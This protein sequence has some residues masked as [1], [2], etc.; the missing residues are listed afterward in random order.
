MASILNDISN[1]S[2]QEFENEIL[3]LFYEKYKRDATSEDF[4]DII[5]LS[6]ANS[7]GKDILSNQVL[8]TILVDIFKGVYG[9]AETNLQ[10]PILRKTEKSIQPKKEYKLNMDTDGNVFIFYNGN[11]YVLPEE[12]SKTLL[13]LGFLHDELTFARKINNVIVPLL[14]NINI[15]DEKDN[16]SHKDKVQELYNKIGEIAKIQYRDEKG[17]YQVEDIDGKIN[18]YLSDEFSKAIDSITSTLF[19]DLLD[20]KNFEG[21][22]FSIDPRPYEALKDMLELGFRIKKD[23][24]IEQKLLVNPYG[25]NFPIYNDAQFAFIDKTFFK[26]TP[27]SF[28]GKDFLDRLGGKIEII[29]LINDHL[30]E[31]MQDLAEKL[32]ELSELSKLSTKDNCDKGVVEARMYLVN[33]AIENLMKAYS[34]KMVTK[35]G[36]IIE[37]GRR[38]RNEY[39]AKTRVAKNA[40]SIRLT[41]MQNE[42]IKRLQDYLVNHGIDFCIYLSSTIES[43]KEPVPIAPEVKYL[44]GESIPIY[45]DQN[46][47]DDEDKILKSIRL[48]CM[49]RNLGL[50]FK[51]LVTKDNGREMSTK[52]PFG[53]KM[54]AP[55][56]A[57]SN[58]GLPYTSDMIQY[59]EAFYKS[60]K[61]NEEFQRMIE[62]EAIKSFENI[63]SN[64]KRFFKLPNNGSIFSRYEARIEANI[65]RILGETEARIGN[66]VNRYM[67]GGE[68][69]LDGINAKLGESVQNILNEGCGEKDN[70]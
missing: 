61:S 30:S 5:Y 51:P 34:R 70:E 47:S 60:G 17:R 21:S 22:I 2:V 19:R 4:Y 28:I 50:E 52:L 66:E 67:K 63:M 43:E 56:T 69:A 53:I 44:K 45:D 25:K 7:M 24:S 48:Y 9:Q 31:H 57:F 65:D 40:N 35:E 46:Q 38:T 8:Y 42:L 41:I 16:Q 54:T 10:K 3:K 37:I 27:K 6:I 39:I 15:E 36:S 20:E 55:F 33:V 49:L 26:R 68:T 32:S 23:N 11:E 1:K 14:N 13:S 59:Y 12:M 62:G 18:I 58:L 29:N 64:F